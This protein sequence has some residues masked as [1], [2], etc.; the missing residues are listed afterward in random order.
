M[1][2][3]PVLDLAT[4]RDLCDAALAA[5]ASR[6]LLVSVAVVDAG[7][8]LVAFARMDGAEIAGPTLAVDKAFTAVAHSAPTHEL[9]VA[10]APG[11]PLFGLHAAGQGRYVIFGGGIPLR[12]EPGGVIVGAV[13][14]S[15]APD[16]A[17]D[18]ACA[19]A[20]VDAAAARW[21]RR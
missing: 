20:A 3:P 19:E 7:G 14:V 16:P 9:A 15:G 5:A 11:G 8:H 4:A 2:Q 12:A 13:G 17:D 21:T 6:S 1:T 18:T 10:A